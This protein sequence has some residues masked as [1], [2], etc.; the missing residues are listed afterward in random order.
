MKRLLSALL[1]VVLAAMIPARGGD[2]GY[3]DNAAFLSRRFLT[4][5]R[6]ASALTDDFLTR[7]A[8][9]YKTPFLFPNGGLLNSQG[10]LDHAPAAVTIFLDHVAAFEREHKVT[11]T[12]MAYLNGYS[13]Q[14]TAHAAG[15]RLDLANPA[16]REKIVTE[17]ERYVSDKPSGS[18]VKGTGRAFDGIMIDIEPA[19]DAAFLDSLKLLLKEIRAA[20]VR[21]G[22]N[23]KKIGVA[24]PQLTRKKPKPNWAWDLSDYHFI[25]RYV[26]TIVAMTYDSGLKTPEYQSWI[27]DQTAQILRAVS[28]AAWNFDADHPQPTNGVKVLIGLPGFYARTNAHIPEIEDVAHGA[29]GIWQA[30]TELNSTNP[31]TLR[32]FQGAAMFSHD[33]GASDSLYARYDADWRWWLEDWLK[34]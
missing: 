6:N 22:L 26:D 25:A 29:P 15:L 1:V 16:V 19:G 28:G 12:L 13:L 14:D 8:K 34:R 30:L 18:Y 24:A 9:F 21:L 23:D 33:G 27:S 11:F 2:A 3:N 20:F 10:V 4:D 32:Y 31:A 7:T 17:C 5:S